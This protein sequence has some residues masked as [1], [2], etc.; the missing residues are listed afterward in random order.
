MKKVEAKDLKLDT[1]Y[2]KL[3]D[4]ELMP[5]EVIP[6]ENIGHPK[7][8]F[9][10]GIESEATVKDT[11]IFFEL[12]VPALGS[13]EIFS[14]TYDT[15]S[16]NDVERDM[17]EMFDDAAEQHPPETLMNASFIITCVMVPEGE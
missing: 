8:F 1:Y 9:C 14:K 10:L 4:G 7:R 5:V 6:G 3:E 2:W 15:D 11:D 17:Y 16:L 12:P 13:A